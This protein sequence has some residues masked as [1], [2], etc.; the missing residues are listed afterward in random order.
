MKFTDIAI[1]NLKPKEK[2]YYLR[3]ANGFTIRVM[4]SGIKTWLHVYT[5]EGKRKEM[6]LGQYPHVSVAEARTRFNRSYELYKLGKD[7]GELERQ[8]RDDRR[9]AHTVSGLVTDYLEKHAKRN[10][11]SWEK[12]EEILNRDV[13]PVWGQ[14]K[15]EDITKR[16]VRNLLDGIIGRGSPG[17]ANNCFQII[18]KMFNYAVDHEIL[19][20]SPCVG[21]K[22]PAQKNSRS[23]TLNE[24]EI[25]ALWQNLDSCPISDET[26]RALK[27]VLVTGQRPNEVAGLPVAE[28]DGRWWT[29]PVT[30]Q[31][32]SKVK[33]CDRS[34]HRIY[35]TDLALELIGNI[36]GKGHAF[37]TPHSTKE[38]PIDSHCLT[39]AVW[40]NMNA[41]VFD[42]E[43][44][45]VMDEDGKHKTENRLGVE[46]F[47]PHDLRRTAATFMAEM[48][49]PDAVIDA[50]LNHVKTG[51]I[52]V[53]N[54]YKYDK[55][56]Q[57]AL[58]AWERK[59]RSILTGEK[60]K[61]IPMNRSQ[62]DGE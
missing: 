51:V 6:N 7:P 2:K 27:L 53:Y 24:Q 43:G 19:A 29:L 40:R 14:R 22:L 42:E 26:R 16:D 49:T 37:P 21:L 18:R 11:R 61:V 52:K 25:K 12:D 32:V 36:E 54:Q 44:N 15:A 34:P 35:L 45:P 23:R 8:E 10:K 47:T 5:F 55:E 46:Q 28:I 20:A 3:E 4:P 59:L 1:K 33:E 9:N 60:G 31:K 13:V 56:K 57:V 62:R 41:T 58:E 38:K 50:V 39:V 17:M 30:R 48:G